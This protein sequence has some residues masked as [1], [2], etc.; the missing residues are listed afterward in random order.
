M[1]LLSQLLYRIHIHS[2]T[3][4]QVIFPKR[5]VPF[6]TT[7]TNHLIGYYDHCDISILNNSKLVTLPFA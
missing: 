3:D 1:G 4:V 6:I 7:L 5:Y 2:Y